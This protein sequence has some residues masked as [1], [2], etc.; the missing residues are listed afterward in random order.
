MIG[1]L[2]GQRIGWQRSFVSAVLSIP[3]PRACV[4]GAGR[5]PFLWLGECESSETSGRNGQHAEKRCSGIGQ[6]PGSEVLQSL[7]P[8]PESNRSMEASYKSLG[9]QSLLLLLHL[10][11][12]R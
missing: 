10:G 8:S 2:L 3:P 12:K 5:V 6:A 9:F 1:R 4:S 11:W 7:I